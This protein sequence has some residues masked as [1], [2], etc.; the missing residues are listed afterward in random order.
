MLM[1]FALVSS[2]V[3]DNKQKYLN[4]YGDFMEEVSKKSKTYS[5]AEWKEAD[6]MYDELNNEL[7]SKFKAEL[8]TDEKRVISGYRIKYKTLKASA[9]INNFYQNLL[10]DDLSRIKKEIKYYIDNKMES[11]L[12]KLLDEA[13]KLSAELHEEL[14]RIKAD[15][16]QEKK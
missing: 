7:Y 6:L 14:L 8:S 13:K 4:D 11:D 10:K 5:K 15:L 16:E 3:R 12:R 9:N 2:C 1:A